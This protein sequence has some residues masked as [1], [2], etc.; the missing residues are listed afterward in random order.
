[1]STCEA[2]NVTR[3]GMCKAPLD[4]HGECPK[5]ADHGDEFSELESPS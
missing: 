2:F 3:A 5:A 4:K 1:M